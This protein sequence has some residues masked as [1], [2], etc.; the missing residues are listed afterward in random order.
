MY[1]L[2][3]HTYVST[4]VPSKQFPLSLVQATSCYR[5]DCTVAQFPCFNLSKSSHMHDQALLLQICCTTSGKGGSMHTDA[6]QNTWTEV[7]NW[8]F[9]VCWTMV[10]KRQEGMSNSPWTPKWCVPWVVQGYH[11]SLLIW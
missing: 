3:A 7:E 10:L 2:L 6:W 11:F 9:Q 4:G 5:H 8:T 1:L